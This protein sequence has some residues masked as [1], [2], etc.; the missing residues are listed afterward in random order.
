ME[1]RELPGYAVFDDYRYSQRI[2]VVVRWFILITWLSFINYRSDESNLLY[3]NVMGGAVILLNGYVSWRIFQ[4]R[5]ITWPY[6]LALSL[7][8]LTIITAG[9]LITS[10]FEN[11]FFVFYY[12]ALLG[13]AL[14][15]RRRI[16]F[17]VVT[18]VAGI[19]IGMS[20]AMEP[21]VD[22]SVLFDGD[23]KQLAVRVVCMFAVVVAAN[24]MTQIER[25]RRREAV[26]AEILQSQRNLELQKRTQEAE[27]AAL[28]ER[29]RIARE[30]HDGVAQSMYALSLNLETAADLAEREQGPLREQLK[31]LVPLAKNTLLET[32]HYIYDLKPLL[33][34]ESDL[35]AVAE[36]HV[37]EFR[38]VA[39]TP[40][41]L[42]IDGE[43]C[44][45][46]VTVATGLY[47]ILQE[48]LANVLKHAHAS[49]VDVT[50]AFE[51]GW[52]RLSVRDDGVSFDTESIRPGYGLENMR[53]RTGELG[54]SIE[55]SSTPDKGACVSVTLPAQEVEHGAH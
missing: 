17:T 43:P 44:Q 18:V 14:I 23:E 42:S 21:G 54:G 26:E 12:P 28:E 40:T 51:P 13:V 46:S 20:V 48:A 39:G 49:E 50:L 25:L 37:K 8:D 32:R 1:K 36:N 30:I 52:V 55:I 29:S 2:A 3:L 6:V 27:L 7:M 22:T 38:M 19:Y 11:T 16:S 45:V 31:K 15:F 5:H 53:H 47:R 10:R 24:L 9:I 4:G 35:V 41:K 34:G 33:S